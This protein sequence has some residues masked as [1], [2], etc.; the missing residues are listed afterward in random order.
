MNANLTVLVGLS[1]AVIQETGAVTS[2]VLT[3]PYEIQLCTTADGG[4]VFVRLGFN[5][6]YFMSDPDAGAIDAPVPELIYSY[7]NAE[8]CDMSFT[9]DAAVIEGYGVKIISYEYDEP[10]ENTFGLFK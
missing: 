2:T 1:T 7:D 4:N 10:I 6:V 5:P 8:T 3:P 9:D